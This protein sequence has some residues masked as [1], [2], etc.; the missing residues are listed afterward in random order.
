VLVA[1]SVQDWRNSLLLARIDCCCCVCPAFFLLLA[2]SSWLDIWRKHLQAA[3]SKKLVVPALLPPA[4]E[5]LPQ[6]IRALMCKCHPPDQPLLAVPLPAV[7]NK[8]GRSATHTVYMFSC[9][10][11]FGEFGSEARVKLRPTVTHYQHT[12]LVHGTQ[13]E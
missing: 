1:E 12:R 9:C 7:T 3:L 4:P 11:E 10:G 8:R 2:V 13:D 6:A 5:P